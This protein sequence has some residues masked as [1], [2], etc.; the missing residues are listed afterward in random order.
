M[1]SYMIFL[2]GFF[3]LCQILV[4]KKKYPAWL[5]EGR[6]MRTTLAGI[7]A[8]LL[9]I[10]VGVLIHMPMILPALTSMYMGSIIADKYREIFDRMERGQRV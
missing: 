2:G 5:Q 7:A 3:I 4:A 1:Y 6:A 9:S 8:I 10:V